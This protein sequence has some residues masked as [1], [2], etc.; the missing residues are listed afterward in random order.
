[1]RARQLLA[2][3]VLTVLLAGCS[4]D[5]GPEPRASDVATVARDQVKDGGTLRWAV[6]AVPATLNVFQPE[7]TA[8]S[9]LLTEALLPHLFR[10]DD[11]A[12]PT[13]DPDYLA[14]AE[15]T[16][17]GQRPQTVTYRLNPKAV[18]TDG[19]PI[20]AAD[21]IA[22]W[23]ALGEAADPAYRTDR[24]AGYAA[25]AAVTQGADAREVKVAFKQSY[26]GWRTLFSPLYPAAASATPAAFNQ[27]L[28]NAPSAGPFTVKT[29]DRAGGKATVVRNPRW[30]GDPAKAEAIDF[31]ATPAAKRLDALDQGTL[32]IAALTD[33]VDHATPAAQTNA[34]PPDAAAVAEASAQALRRAEALPGLKLHRAVAPAFAQLTLNGTR[35]PLAD[36]A[37]RRAVARAVDRQRVAE[38]AVNPLGLTPVPLGHHLLMAGQDGYQDNSSAAGG[39]SAAELLD[40]AGWHPGGAART[41]DGKELA[42][43]LLIPEGSAGARR[44][45]DA[46]TAGLAEAGITLRPQAVPAESFLTDHLATGE[47]DLA[48]FSWPAGQDATGAA[49]RYGKPRPGPDGLPVIGRNYARTGS[50]EID[51]LLAQADAELDPAA[52]RALLQEADARIWQVAHSVPLYQRPDLVAVRTEV[53]NAGAF[54][55]ATPRFQDLGLRRG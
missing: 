42:L 9:E 41:K 35:G 46:L 49:A 25:I 10:W 12:R 27:P 14:A 8:D 34:A 30:W 55:F 28:T 3:A 2:V 31:L 36:P 5:P 40:Q 6:E 17:A 50:E 39:A 37:V 32:D 24:P 43:G 21:F 20:T 47:Y 51:Q 7:A 1:M 38:A 48:L 15:S 45:A 33:A 54:G 52:R 16:P 29:Y 23:H 44:A 53:A 18:W 22:Q 19:T 26:A 4:E 13:A 11:H